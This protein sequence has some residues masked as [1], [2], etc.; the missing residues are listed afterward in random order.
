[1]SWE[2]HAL[3]TDDADTIRST[4]E[5]AI[6]QLIDTTEQ[7][8]ASGLPVPIVS[9]GGSGT[10]GVTPFI[11][12]VTEVQA[13]GAIFNDERYT[14]WGVRTDPA[15]FL[16]SVVT[17]RPTPDRIVF[18]AGYKTLPVWHGPPKP[19]GIDHIKKIAMSAE[20]GI[21]TLEQANESVQVGDVFDFRLGYSD[22][23]V[24]L[25]DELIGIRNGK[26]ETVWKIEG[27]G[28]LQ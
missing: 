12:G 2:G 13:G 9:C 18:D 3:A 16:R 14:A 20:H 1:M 15:I 26:V 23:T 6:H 17:S 11:S 28:R 21:V 22:A 10:Y 25:H 19:I 8:R 27:R 5:K 24:F 4:A 7:V